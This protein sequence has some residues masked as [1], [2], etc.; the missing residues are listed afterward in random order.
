MGRISIFCS[1]AAELQRRCACRS[2]IPQDLP[3]DKIIF[4]ANRF[5]SNGKVPE[6]TH[7]V[8]VDLEGY[9]QLPDQNAMRDV[10]RAVGQLNKLLPKRQFILI[11]PGRWGSRGD[12][13]LGVPV[14]Y[15]DINNTA[16]LIEVARQRGNYLPESVV[17][18]LTFS[19]IWSRLLFAICRSIRTIPAPRLTTC[20]FAAPATCFRIC[21]LNSHTLQET[22]RVIDV[23]LQT[24]G[25]KLR[26]L[27]NADLQ[28]A[29]GFL[30]PA[31]QDIDPFAAG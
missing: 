28:Q 4:S 2:A 27:M 7:I 14:T 8:Y 26:V 22:L 23:P 30:S 15:S 19:R 24:G 18:A 29:V 20:F 31:Q 3:P 9:S 5:V 11:G 6:I 16:M 25:L 13:K 12:I 17:S 10:G 1:A 21:S